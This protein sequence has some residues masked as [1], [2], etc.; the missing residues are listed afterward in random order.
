MK[1]IVNEVEVHHKTFNVDLHPSRIGPNTWD[2]TNGISV[3]MTLSID[4]LFEIHKQL[5]Q[6]LVDG[7]FTWQA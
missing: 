3:N 6:K 4:D 1:P 5:T 7:D 2:A